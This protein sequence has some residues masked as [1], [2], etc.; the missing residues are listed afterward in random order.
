MDKVFHILERP[1]VYFSV[2]KENWSGRLLLAQIVWMAC[3]LFFHNSLTCKRLWEKGEKSKQILIRKSGNALFRLLKD[4][5]SY[6]NTYDRIVRHWDYDKQLSKADRLKRFCSLHRYRFM[7]TEL[8]ID[9][10]RVVRLSLSPSSK[11]LKKPARKNGRARS[12]MRE[13]RKKN[14]LLARP[15]FSR[16]SLSRL[17]R[18]TE[19]KRDYS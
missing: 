5:D 12:W 16:G 17:A 8:R 15:F 14:V 2:G 4:R 13:A 1:D 18:R 9:V 7:F 6:F 3:K 11:T 10:L 19:R